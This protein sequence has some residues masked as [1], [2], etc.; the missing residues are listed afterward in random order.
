MARQKGKRARGARVDRIEGEAGKELLDLYIEELKGIP[1]LASEAQKGLARRMRDARL[2]AAERAEA[3]EELIR[4]N[5]RFAFSVAKKY[6]NRGLP[7]EDLVSEANAGLCRATDKYDPDVGVNFISYAVW[8]IRQ[9]IFSAITTKT[10][11]VKVPLG[12]AGDLGRVA[13]ARA[14]LQSRLSREPSPE[15]IAQI[16]GIAVDVV[17]DLIRL[18]VAERSLDEPV[19]GAGRSGTEAPPLAAVL[20]PEPGEAEVTV[21]LEEE[22]RRDALRRALEPLSPRDR[23]IVTLYYGLDSGEPMTLDAISKLLGVTRERVR[24]L[25]DRAI[26]QLRTGDAAELLR[27]EWAA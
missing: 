5:L 25:R 11:T 6:Q 23:R 20:R 7:L 2:P 8:W 19:P 27:R 15:E 9:A 14:V 3:R 10:R 12:R 16:S 4:A 24:Q 22:S 1:L 21:R 26:A 17:K 18:S 13:R